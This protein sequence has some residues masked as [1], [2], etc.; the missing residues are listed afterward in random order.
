MRGGREDL[1]DKVIAVARTADGRVAAFSSAVLLPVAG[2]GEV[3]HLGLTCVAPGERAAGLTRL[4][5]SIS[6]VRYLV[7]HLPLSRL[8][9][10][11]LAC[12]LSSLGNVA[13]HFERV[14]PSPLNGVEPGEEHLR[15]ARAVDRLHRDKLF[16]R[17][18]AVFDEQ[19]FVFRRSVRDTVFQKQAHDSAFHHRDEVLNRFYRERMA[20]D[21]GDEVLQVGSITLLGLARYFLQ[22][23]TS[24][25]GIDRDRD[26]AVGPGRML[27]LP[28]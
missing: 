14:Y 19:A 13:L 6:L 4:L 17:R 10:T 25:P 18:E 9:V 11:N 21:D 7:S 8:W 5:S 3:F 2:V 27:P 1:R 16:I 28:V 24:F 22:R 12:V 15:I 23:R 20:F 26:G